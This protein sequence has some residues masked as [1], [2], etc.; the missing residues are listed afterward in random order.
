MQPPPLTSSETFL[1]L[2]HSPYPLCSFPCASSAWSLVVIWIPSL[3]IYQ[4]WVFTINGVTQYVTFFVSGFFRVWHNVYPHLRRV[5]Y[6]FSGLRNTPPCAIIGL[7]VHWWSRL[8]CWR[9]CLSNVEFWFGGL[10]QQHL[11]YF[12]LPYSV[13]HGFY[14]QICSKFFFFFI[15]E[16]GFS[17]KGRVGEKSF[18]MF[19]TGRVNFLSFLVL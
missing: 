7:S 19:L 1:S 6:S 16:V 3:W 11:N 13:L 17:P 8:H 12:A 10:F 2:L 9:I 4:F 18:P 14:R 5:C 15:G